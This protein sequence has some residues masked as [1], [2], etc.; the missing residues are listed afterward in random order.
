M[1]VQMLVRVGPAYVFLRAFLVGLIPVMAALVT[2][3]VR[4]IF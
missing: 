4:A 2:E 1:S 3:L